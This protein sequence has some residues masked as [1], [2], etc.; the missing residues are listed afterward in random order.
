MRTLYFAATTVALS[1]IVFVLQ[2]CGSD[3]PDVTTDA[4]ATSSDS[5]AVSPAPNNPPVF[6][7]ATLEQPKD[8]T[9]VYAAPTTDQVRDFRLR[10]KEALALT[11]DFRHEDAGVVLDVFMP[12][13]EKTT[14]ITR[15]RNIRN[16]ISQ[17]LALFWSIEKRMPLEPGQEITVPAPDGTSDWRVR[18]ISK[19]NIVLD[20]GNGAVSYKTWDVVPPATQY[21]IIG[22]LIDRDSLTEQTRLIVFCFLRNLAK[23]RENETNAA[24]SM[25]GYPDSIEKKMV[26]CMAAMDD[27]FGDDTAPLSQSAP[28]VAFPAIDFPEIS[29]RVEPIADHPF[30]DKAA[31]STSTTPEITET[32][33]VEPQD[34]QPNGDIPVDIVE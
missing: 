11:R 4:D 10:V 9:T 6:R 19:K 18:S 29:K 12:A 34:G 20:A 13:V 7:R 28:D 25:V 24:I 16:L 22:R 17:D 27:I 23:A 30:E 8:D 33:I 26:A 15:I 32:L 31:T 2:G 14:L 3:E 5:T 1:F 21:E